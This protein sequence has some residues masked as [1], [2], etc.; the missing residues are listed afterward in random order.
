MKITFTG[1]RDGMT[2]AQLETVMRSI[3]ELRISNELN[4]L[5]HG[6]CHG[7]DRQA[8]E[9]V[10]RRI[11]HPSNTEQLSWAL[12]VKKEQDEVL[13]IDKDPIRRNRRMVNEGRAVV[14][15]PGTFAEVQRSGTW[16]TIR[17]ARKL[18]RPLY[19]CFPDGNVH[20]ENL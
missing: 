7:A 17:Y 14:A 20:S 6:A 12:S 3:R 15:A 13:P 2:T 8:H 1:T 18:E 10:M 11:M 9:L 5:I 19:I 16:A 4:Y